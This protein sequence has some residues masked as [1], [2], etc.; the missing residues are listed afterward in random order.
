M[1]LP[2]IK[3][4][5][6]GTFF[7]ERLT[8]EGLSIWTK[9]FLW[10][11]EYFARI[12]AVVLFIPIMAFILVLPSRKAT[13]KFFGLLNMISSVFEDRTTEEE[14]EL[15]RKKNEMGKVQRVDSGR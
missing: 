12:I 10:F 14:L 15:R 9:T 13:K 1:K 6:I 11:V 4:P 5:N 3:L 8:N 2:K 7:E